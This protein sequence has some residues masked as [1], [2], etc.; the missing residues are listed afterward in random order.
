MPANVRHSLV[1]AAVLAASVLCVAVLSASSSE[2]V[3]SQDKCTPQTVNIFR[4]SLERARVRL[5]RAAQE[6]QA[7]QQTAKGRAAQEQAAPVALVK[8]EATKVEAQFERTPIQHEA[9]ETA[10]ALDEVVTEGISNESAVDTVTA[11]SGD[12]ENVPLPV[13]AEMPAA[14]PAYQTT[15]Q[16]LNYSL[17]CST[18]SCFN[19]NFCQACNAPGYCP[20]WRDEVPCCENC[21]AQLKARLQARYWGYPEYF[22]ERRFGSVNNQVAAMMV[23]NGIGDQMVLYEYD[24]GIAADAASLKERGVYQ[25][26]KMVRRMQIV[27]HPIV[28]EPSGDPQLDVERQNQVLAKLAELG[29]ELEREL[30]VVARPGVRGLD[31]IEA[32]PIY[33]NI[34]Q[35]TSARGNVGIETSGLSD[36]GLGSSGTGGGASTGINSGGLQ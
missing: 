13:P 20:C 18:P 31:G 32:L 6:Q 23:Y 19:P 28:I 34:L 9:V 22:C 35:Q 16:P 8:R 11:E 29:V 5:E 33:S 12:V 27:C 1:A 30:V 26:E 14:A 2:I 4:Q 3:K 17:S 25:L 15:K 7:T 21:R 36:I 10:L 24:F